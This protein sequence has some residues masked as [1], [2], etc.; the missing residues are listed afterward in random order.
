[1]VLSLCNIFSNIYEKILK[2]I[3]SGTFSSQIML[4]YVTT[5]EVRIVKLV[6]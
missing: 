2:G 3:E 5:D 4:M 6:R 1:M